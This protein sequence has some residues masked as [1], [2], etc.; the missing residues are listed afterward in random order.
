LAV[1]YSSRH[2]LQMWDLRLL[3]DQ[4]TELGLDWSRPPFPAAANE[5]GKPVMPVTW[6]DQIS[7]GKP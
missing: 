5:E 3:R 4:L 2:E 1:T 6:I 7:P